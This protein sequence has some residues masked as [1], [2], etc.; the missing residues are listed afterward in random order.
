MKPLIYIAGPYTIP[1]PVENVHHHMRWWFKIAE[2]G[3]MVPV[4]PTLSMFLHLLHPKPYE[5]WLDIDFEVL[6]HC[7]AMFRIKG[8][9]KGADMEEKKAE[10]LDIPVFYDDEFDRLIEWVTKT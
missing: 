5:F 2:G 1:D 6:A 8:E 4:M 7:Q 9:S 10:E 3:L